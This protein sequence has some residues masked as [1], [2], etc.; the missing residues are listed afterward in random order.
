M[1]GNLQHYLSILGLTTPAIELTARRPLLLVAAMREIR[2]PL[3]LKAQR[4][5]MLLAAE[6]G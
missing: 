2:D 5:L 3:S 6:V 1:L 4:W